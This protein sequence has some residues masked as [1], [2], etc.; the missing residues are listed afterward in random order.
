MR[1][2]FRVRA[3]TCCLILVVAALA[4]CSSAPSVSPPISIAPS[5][6]TT[7]ATPPQAATV[8]ATATTTATASTEPKARWALAAFADLPGW[9]A[10]D[11]RDVRVAFAENCKG[12]RSKPEW[13]NACSRFPFDAPVATQR[14][15]IESE[16]TPYQLT[17]ADA[18]DRGL[19]TGYYEP[20]LKGSRTKTA[21]FNVP[22][23]ARPDDLLIVDLGDVHPELRGKR[24]RGRLVDSPQGKRVVP[25]H[26]R[27]QIEAQPLLFKPLVWVDEVVEAFFLQI[28]GSGLIELADG[29]RL[30]AGYADQNGH[31]FRGIGRILADRGEMK[32]EEVSMQGIKG[33]I[34]RNPDKA[35]ALL[36]ENASY[37]FFREIDATAAGPLGSLGVP[38]TAERSIA[39]DTRFIP[40][41][42]LVYMATTYPN[43]LAPLNRLMFAQDTGGAIRGVVRADFYWGTGHKAGEQ[44][45][46]MKQS[47][48]MWVLWPKGTV[49][50]L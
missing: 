23:Y 40:L 7:V 27:A 50:P 22:L 29:K 18:P 26:D 8:T 38:L 16:F 33:W 13:V 19:I 5:A 37:V 1:S 39:V 24:V 31:P 10:D 46:R 12:L 25:Y 4:A 21:K 14:A 44:A 6:P 47:A 28:Q 17:R 15:F 11:L 35:T 34:S 20:L 43:A 48:Q 2:T 41:G 36:N 32:L 9:G 30:R 3:S 45:G 49:P 42:A